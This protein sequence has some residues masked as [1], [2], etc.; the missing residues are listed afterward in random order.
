VAT[1]GMVLE[2]VAVVAGTAAL[3]EVAAD[4]SGNCC[5]K[6][7]S[8]SSPGFCELVLERLLADSPE[9]TVPEFA[10][11]GEAAQAPVLRDKGRRLLTVDETW[12]RCSWRNVQEEIAPGSARGII[13]RQRE[14]VVVEMVDVFPDQSRARPNRDVFRRT[15][16]SSGRKRGESGPERPFALLLRLQTL[17]L[18]SDQSRRRLSSKSVR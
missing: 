1:P 7:A 8:R 6:L 2:A 9:S 17:E 10:P 5:R 15:R 13:Q 4:T 16:G 14:G 3:V 12:C 18:V 11:G